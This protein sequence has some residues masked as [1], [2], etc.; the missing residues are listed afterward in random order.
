MASV[1]CCEHDFLLHTTSHLN[2]PLTPM[3]SCPL[4][5]KLYQDQMV[6]LILSAME[7]TEPAK[8]ESALQ[9]FTDVFQECEY[10][11]SLV[12]EIFLLRKSSFWG[13]HSH[14]G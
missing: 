5:A 1:V 7:S 10:E 12:L 4:I 3:Y 13:R 9:A 14:V 8:I 6:S 2:I 11:L